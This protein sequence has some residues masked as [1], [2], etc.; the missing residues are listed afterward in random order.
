MKPRITVANNLA[1]TEG[2]VYKGTIISLGFGEGKRTEKHGRDIEEIIYPRF[3]MVC[4]FEG[5]VK[6]IRINT[7]TGVS[8]NAEPLEVRYEGRG[9]K[10]EVKIYNRFTNLLLRLGLVQEEELESVDAK[11]V[12]R[13]EQDLNSLK[14]LM[15]QSKIGKDKGGYL[16]LDLETLELVR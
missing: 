6:P 2:D 7:Y 10:N 4:E 9:A 8:I 15:I 3:E 16:A 12:E 14:G 5:T 1:K 11:T 13:I